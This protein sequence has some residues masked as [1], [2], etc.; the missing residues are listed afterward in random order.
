MDDTAHH[1]PDLG[2]IPMLYRVMH[3]TNAQGFEG[4]LLLPVSF[5][6]TPN[7]GDPEPAF[8]LPHT[9]LPP[10]FDDFGFIYAA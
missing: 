1:S 8:T 7:L 3:T 2:R 4:P 9:A 6:R 10:R 5:D